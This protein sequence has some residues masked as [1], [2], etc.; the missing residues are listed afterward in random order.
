V[1]L[2]TACNAIRVSLLRALARP[3]AATGYS[4]LIERRRLL[5]HW[6]SPGALI[7]HL[8]R[9]GRVFANDQ[10]LRTLVHAT[11]P[12]LPGAEVAEQILWVVLTP[13][14]F[15]LAAHFVRGPENVLEAEDVV[16][17]LMERFTIALRHRHCRRDVEAALE[18]TALVARF[19]LEVE[20][21]RRACEVLVDPADVE[22]LV[23][24]TSCGARDPLAHLYT[25]LGSRLG[26]HSSIL[27]AVAV[28]GLNCAEV[29]RAIGRSRSRVATIFHQARR[30]ARSLLADDDRP[31]PGT[32]RSGG[33]R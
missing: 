1:C 9:R 27:F 23:P 30:R 19:E 12:C 24:A 20:R 14:L 21:A 26:S 25:F 15:E 10:I 11:K 22:L 33:V 29:G 4:Q 31:A 3:T 6:P 32:A 17:V 2:K 13:T 28:V 18:A 5:R 16:G 7:T 8:E